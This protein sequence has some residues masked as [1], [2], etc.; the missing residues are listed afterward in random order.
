MAKI[1]IIH[2]VAHWPLHWAGHWKANYAPEGYSYGDI[3]MRQRDD[4][5]LLLF[6]SVVNDNHTDPCLDVTGAWQQIEGEYK[7]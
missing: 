2:E 3:V 5:A 1:G 4:W 7:S 6:V